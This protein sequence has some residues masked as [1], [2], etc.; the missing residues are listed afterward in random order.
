MPVN[1]RQ[2]MDLGC[3]LA[4]LILRSGLLEHKASKWSGTSGRI[5]LL[6][7][8]FQG[9]FIEI[10]TSGP[11]KQGRWR[12]GQRS[13]KGQDQGLGQRAGHQSRGDRAGF[14]VISGRHKSAASGKARASENREGVGPLC[15]FAPVF[16][17]VKPEEDQRRGVVSDSRAGL[18]CFR[19][20]PSH[21]KRSQ[22]RKL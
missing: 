7:G 12:Q 11:G 3:S 19:R 10:K 21:R 8:P 9:V 14:L 16:D 4:L 6:G 22:I 17:L 5:Q 18:R 2:I 20:R 15:R 1:Q 13:L